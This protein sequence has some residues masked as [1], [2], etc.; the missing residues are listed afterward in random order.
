MVQQTDEAE[1]LEAFLRWIHPAQ[2]RELVLDLFTTKDFV[3][4]IHLYWVWRLADKYV[5]AEVGAIIMKIVRGMIKT[6]PDRALAIAALIRDPTIVREALHRWLSQR[7]EVRGRIT[8]ST[9]DGIIGRA[10]EDSEY[11]DAERRRTPSATP[12]WPGSPTYGLVSSTI[13]PLKPRIPWNDWRS[14]VGQSQPTSVSDIQPSLLAALGLGFAVHLDKALKR[15]IH[16]AEFDEASVING[17]MAAF[18][19]RFPLACEYID[20][21]HTKRTHSD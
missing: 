12:P 3:P 2:L 6:R 20:V 15:M 10:E 16:S 4:D 18:E 9:V 21:C 11:G 17:F 5:A 8:V 7:E 1:Q 14:L 13:V 19:S